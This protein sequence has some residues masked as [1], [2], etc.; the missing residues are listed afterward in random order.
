MEKVRPFLYR[1]AQLGFRPMPGAHASAMSGAGQLFKRHDS[2]L[3]NPDARRLDLRA[4]VLNPFQE[5]KVKVYQQASRIPMLVIADLSLS[6]SYIGLSNKQ[7]AL[8][9]FAASAAYSAQQTGDSFTFIGCGRQ[10]DTRWLTAGHLGFGAI[11]AMADALRSR[12]LTGKAESLTEVS[13]YVPNKR[14]L[15]FVVSDFHLPAERITT[16][17]GRLTGHIV[18][19]VVLW[20]E[21][22][23][24][25]LP[26][27]GIWKVKDLES[28]AT[29]TL[30]LRPGYKQKIQVAFK[31]HRQR[32]QQLC[33]AFS[34]EPLFINGTYN[35][36][37]VT[38]YFYGR[39]V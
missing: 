37:V 10:A 12:Q 3:A 23:Y 17:L 26:N 28:N 34:A 29:R 33:R 13:Q 35:A 25:A 18:I 38:A 36:D 20:D 15:I 4:S 21:A 8:A 16:L 32:L 31:Q 6:M 7:Q 11:P 19:P 1:I 27:W 9:D 5:F 39:A 24:A 22:E 30:L 2:L 14:S